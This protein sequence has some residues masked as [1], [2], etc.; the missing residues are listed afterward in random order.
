MKESE[1]KKLVIID[2]DNDEDM[3]E[4]DV[5]DFFLYGKSIIN[6]RENKK[7]GQS[8]TYYQIIGKTQ[9]GVEYIPIYDYMEKDEGEIKQ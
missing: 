8:I 5:D 2:D 6:Q 3:Q 1:F 7:V 9:H 4:L